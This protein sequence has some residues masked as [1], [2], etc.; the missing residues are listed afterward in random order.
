MARMDPDDLPDIESEQAF[1]V[2]LGQARIRLEIPQLM[3]RALDCNPELVHRAIR[4]WASHVR[5]LSE[6]ADELRGA[7][8][9]G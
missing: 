2:I 4:E 5:P 6:I 7:L 8:E 1:Q 9:E 3:A